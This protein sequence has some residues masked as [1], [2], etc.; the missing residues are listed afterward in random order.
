[1]SFTP[2]LLAGVMTDYDLSNRFNGFS[3]S[4][5]PLKTVKTV[6]QF[7]GIGFTGLKPGVNE[8]FELMESAKA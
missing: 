3:I 5:A 1:M 7:K 8:K 2:W 4:P 6:P